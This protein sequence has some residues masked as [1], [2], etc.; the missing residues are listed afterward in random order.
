MVAAASIMITSLAFFLGLVTGS[1]VE[2]SRSA[3]VKKYG[4]YALGTSLAVALLSAIWLAVLVIRL[5]VAGASV[6]R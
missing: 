2:A 6:V 1:E 5:A 4:Y 3:K